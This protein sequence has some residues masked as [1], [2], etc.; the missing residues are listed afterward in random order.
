MIFDVR[1]SQRIFGEISGGKILCDVVVLIFTHC[2]ADSNELPILVN[3]CF[4]VAWR[5]VQLILRT[6]YIRTNHNIFT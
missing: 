3:G 2:N 6:D 4:D 1:P 5:T